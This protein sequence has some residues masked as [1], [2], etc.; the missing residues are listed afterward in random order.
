MSAPPARTHARTSP[1]AVALD[2]YQW[3][4]DVGT[5]NDT[6]LPVAVVVA[7]F[8]GAFALLLVVGIVVILRNRRAARATD[9]AP[10]LRTPLVVE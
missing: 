3:S 10:G 2:P 9:A 7:G 5:S 8:G 4:G 1:R 6:T